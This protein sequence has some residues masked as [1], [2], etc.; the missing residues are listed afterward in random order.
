ME[1][2]KIARHLHTEALKKWIKGMSVTTKSFRSENME[3]N[4]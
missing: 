2:M 1:Y 4:A 3:L